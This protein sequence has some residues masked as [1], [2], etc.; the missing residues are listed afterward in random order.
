MGVEGI[1]NDF[2]DDKCTSII[3]TH[4]PKGE[5]VL[6]ELDNDIEFK[7]TDLEFAYQFNRAMYNSGVLK[8]SRKVIFDKIKNNE[9]FR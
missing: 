6:N 4:T 2:D 7:S 3:I 1:H 8:D 9:F 5:K